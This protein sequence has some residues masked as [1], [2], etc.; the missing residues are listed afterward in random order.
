MTP[1]AALEA[2][3]AAA[4]PGRA[5]EMARYHRQTREVLGTPRTPRSSPWGAT[6][7]AR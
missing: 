2:L 4:D 7:A 1:E 3:R 6:G 5:A